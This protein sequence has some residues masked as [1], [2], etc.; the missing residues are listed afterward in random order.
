MEGAD[1]STELWR[2]PTIFDVCVNLCFPEGP[3][4]AHKNKDYNQ[5]DQIGQF[6][7]LLVKNFLLKVIQ[8]C[9]GF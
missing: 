4:L 5:C 9:E 1:K 2:P 8:M 7:K 6:R 3:H